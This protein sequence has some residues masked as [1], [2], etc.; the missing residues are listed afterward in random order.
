MFDL[1]SRSQDMNA[2][3]QDV[4]VVISV[5]EPCPK[6]SPFSLYPT[7]C[8][9]AKREASEAKNAMYAAQEAQKE[10]QELFD[11]ST[12]ENETLRL[13]EMK[14]E[15]TLHGIRQGQKAGKEASK[16]S[17]SPSFLLIRPKSQ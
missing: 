10:I 17:H 7:L 9:Q 1:V 14:L 2:L 15:T 3:K 16:L 11:M 12:K 5:H 8:L 4:T 13:Q 6:I